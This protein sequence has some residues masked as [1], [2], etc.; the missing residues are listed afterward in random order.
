MYNTYGTTN[1]CDVR[2]LIKDKLNMLEEKLQEHWLHNNVMIGMDE[3]YMFGVLSQE[4]NYAL[5]TFIHE[6]D[7]VG[8]AL[9]G[10]LFEELRN[11]ITYERFKT[12]CTL[13][14]PT[15]SDLVHSMSK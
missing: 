3:L 15:I 9:Q 14:I 12:Y 8:Y 1:T 13:K 6:H 5:I 4:M 7:D 2:I 10:L 11:S